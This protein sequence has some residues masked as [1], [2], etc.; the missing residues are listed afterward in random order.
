MRRFVCGRGPRFIGALL[1]CFLASLSSWGQSSSP[2][3][4]GVPSGD[5]GSSSLD[6]LPPFDTGKTYQVPGT[7]LE[8]L[9]QDWL[10]LESKLTQSQAAL[11][12]AKTQLTLAQARLDGLQK[13]LE[14][15]NLSLTTS[16]D[17][18]RAYRTQTS[19]ELWSWR[20]LSGLGLWFAI[21]EAGMKR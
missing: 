6:S 18:F 13:P 20:I 9:R 14:V 11:Q 7:T 8:K 10:M 4:G 21:Y 5:S 17:S 15:L 1:L 19:L 12:E 16:A 2:S 3:L